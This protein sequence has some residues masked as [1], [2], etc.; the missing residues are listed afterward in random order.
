[1]ARS[2]ALR[3]SP[4]RAGEVRAAHEQLHHRTTVLALRLLAQDGAQPGRPLDV[5]LVPPE[6]VADAGDAP[7]GQGGGGGGE[8][9]VHRA[10][11]VEDRAVHGARLVG[12]G[13][14]AGVG[15]AVPGEHPHG[16]VD[17]P[18]RQLVTALGRLPGP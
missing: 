14:G 2:I 8:E 18:G 13:T 11:V 7:V 4:A 3:T 17:E 1:M 15:E 9:A 6:T 10:E 16:G 12:D 5:R